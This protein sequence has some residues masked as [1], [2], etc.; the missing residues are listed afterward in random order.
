MDQRVGDGRGP[1]DPSPGGVLG[2]EAA[3]DGTYCWAKQRR[4]TV[5]A[6]CATTLLGLEEVG[7]DAT[8]DGE[9]CGATQAGKEAERDHLPL[10]LSEAAAEVEEEV[11]CIGELEDYGTAVELG[12]GPEEEGPDGVGENEDGKRQA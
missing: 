5:D 8:T 9:W 1:E 3:G 7:E 11:E 12:E 10:G 4:K 2:D 6:D